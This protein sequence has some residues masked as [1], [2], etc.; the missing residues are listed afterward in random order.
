M[1]LAPGFY[2]KAVVRLR[3]LCHLNGQSAENPCLVSG[4]EVVHTE[5]AVVAVKISSIEQMI[6]EM[7]HKEVA[8]EIAVE[9]LR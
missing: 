7:P 3:H 5:P 8:A 4:H 1:A 6:S 2:H 9:R